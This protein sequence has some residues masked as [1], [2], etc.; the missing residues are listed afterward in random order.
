MPWE[1][2]EELHFSQNPI[3]FFPNNTIVADEGTNLALDS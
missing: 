1:A 3:C 2:H